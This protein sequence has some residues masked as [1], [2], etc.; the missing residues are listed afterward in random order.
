MTTSNH[1][2]GL[3]HEQQALTEVRMSIAEFTGV[4]IGAEVKRLRAARAS[5]TSL[6]ALKG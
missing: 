4:K 2:P 3:H 1:H 6:R 5:L